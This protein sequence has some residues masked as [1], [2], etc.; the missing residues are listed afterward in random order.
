MAKFLPPREKGQV[1]QHLC[2]RYGEVNKCVRLSHVTIA[3][4]S[5]NMK[6]HH[7]LRVAAGVPHPAA[8]AKSPEHQ[9]KITAA[10]RARNVS[11]SEERRANISRALKASPKFAKFIESNRGV[12]LSDERKAKIS[13][14]RR[15]IRS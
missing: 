4:R 10:L 9:A 3:S 1:V 12:P 15:R 5:D 11:H 13:E 2:E 7:A 14:A 6:H 8:G